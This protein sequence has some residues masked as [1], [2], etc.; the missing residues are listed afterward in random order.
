MK[1]FARCFWIFMS[2]SFALPGFS[3]GVK[4]F[5]TAPTAQVF[6]GDEVKM[7]LVIESPIAGKATLNTA[8]F[9]TL[10]AWEVIQPGVLLDSVQKS[11]VIQ[12]RQSVSLICWEPGTYALPS[13]VVSFMP[14]AAAQVQEAVVQGVTLTVQGVQVIEGMD[15]K[16][17]KGPVDAPI[18]AKEVFFFA[19]PFL[20][21]AILLG[22][23]GWVAYSSKK[24]RRLAPPPPAEIIP[25]HVA[26]LRL[27][28]TIAE[29]A[30]WKN[31]DLKG[32]YSAIS[33]TVREYLEKRYRILALEST[34]YEI[35]RDLKKR[36]T[37]PQGLDT[38]SDLLE[39][40]DMVKFARSNPDEETH[41]Q[42]LELAR[43][44]IQL[45]PAPEPVAR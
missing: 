41:V 11:G 24:H 42:A 14:H 4:A 17:I 39:T 26:H 5:W 3:Q 7:T 30:V 10:R 23:L 22:W 37:P 38:L 2:F 33:D 40:A 44:F 20:V 19:L 43:Q 9:D 45:N 36:K 29:Q 25:L 15:F 8:P 32:Y 34:T 31:G 21:L 18:T 16:D 35:L 28:D 27:L 13:T 1:R 6:I 12:Y